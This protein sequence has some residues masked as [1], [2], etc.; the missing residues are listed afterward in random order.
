M[1]SLK[2]RVTLSLI[3]KGRRESGSMLRL[4]HVFDSNNQRQITKQP[5]LPKKKEPLQAKN[6]KD[7]P[8]IMTF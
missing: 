6:D 4:R 5:E 1:A 8:I 2:E 3:T 7:I